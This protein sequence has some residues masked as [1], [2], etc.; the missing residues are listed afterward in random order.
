MS[1]HDMMA[2]AL[3]PYRGKNLSTA[4]IRIIVGEAFPNFN[5]GSLLPNDHA[6]G[7]K[8]PCW[9]AGGNPT[10]RFLASSHRPW[11]IKYWFLCVPSD[12]T[13]F[14]K[15]GRWATKLLL[16]FVVTGRGQTRSTSPDVRTNL[17]KL[18]Y[19]SE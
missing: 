13:S 16:P 19:S 15:V 8:S 10:C 5:M 9:C 2:S 11:L 7:N 3:K 14:L 6:E 4:E 17:F 12:G 1:N 18:E